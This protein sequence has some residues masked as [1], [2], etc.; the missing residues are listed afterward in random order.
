M[1]DP[2]D[3]NDPGEK[4]FDSRWIRSHR[5]RKN[6]VDPY[7]PYHF[8]TE[9]ERSLEGTMEKVITLFL[10]NRECPYTC[11]MC[12]LWK[13]TTDEP[14]P[15]GAVP[16]QIEWALKQIP[17]APHIKLYNSANFFDPLAIPTED[18]PR[19]AKLLEPF[20][21]VVV[22]NHPRMTGELL[23][24]F[25]DMIRPQ[26]QV[27]MGLETIHPGGLGQLN[28]KMAP[29]DFRNAAGLLQ[30]HGI[31]TRAFILLRP[32]FLSE[33][34]G[35]YWAKATVEYAFDSGAECCVVI[36]TRAGNGAMEQLQKE[37]DFS[38]PTLDSL[39]EVLAHGIAL[40]RGNVFADTWDLHQ[41]SNCEKCFDAR[42]K[43]MEQ[44]NLRQ[45]LLPPVKCICTL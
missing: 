33:E 20:E 36:P 14:V 35:V 18:Y 1:N 11:L 38:S 5:G 31:G 8:L 7:R 37:G 12:D 24:R 21:T 28:K 15:V 29:E 40:G 25:A 6:R 41:F 10:T 27:A 43:R 34:E 4:P 2:G 19:I 9:E 3:M 30:D 17:P 23:F 44:M 42:S 13:H 45:E 16:A 32:P 39:E 26:M 22:E